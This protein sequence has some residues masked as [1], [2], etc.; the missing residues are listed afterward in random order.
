MSITVFVFFLVFR[1]LFVFL[2]MS[3][4]C[5][6]FL[7]FAFNF[8]ALLFVCFSWSLTRVL[9][10]ESCN[11]FIDNTPMYVFFGFYLKL[12]PQYTRVSFA[13]LT[14]DAIRFW[15]TA[16]AFGLLRRYPQS[17]TYWKQ[18]MSQLIKKRKR[19]SAVAVAT[20]TVTHTIF[21]CGSPTTAT[22]RWAT[23]SCPTRTHSN[24][25]RRN[26]FNPRRELISVASLKF[27]MAYVLLSAHSRACCISLSL[28][29]W[30]AGSSAHFR[31]EPGT[32]NAWRW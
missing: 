32:G 9:I 11:L 30:L 10:D 12:L 27:K 23:Y 17:K 24:S 28:T 22:S 26:V 1:S 21:A 8:C 31:P 3:T 7:R 20:A 25:H 2:F 19:E 13:D 29:S 14:V 5:K 15:S 16:V 4:F 6:L 18:R